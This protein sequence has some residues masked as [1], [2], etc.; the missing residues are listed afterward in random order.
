MVTRSFSQLFCSHV[1][2]RVAVGQGTG[3]CCPCLQRLSRGCVSWMATVGWPC[4]CVA[5]ETST[6]HGMQQ[7]VNSKCAMS[8]RADGCALNCKMGTTFGLFLQMKFIPVN[9]DS[10][11]DQKFVLRH[12]AATM[13]AVVGGNMSDPI[14]WYCTSRW[15][16]WVVRQTCIHNARV[17]C[18]GPARGCMSKLSASWLQ[19][20][21]HVIIQHPQEYVH[22]AQQQ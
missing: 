2:S 21:R 16:M 18:Q 5:D 7:I 10:E 8:V 11:H 13:L 22:M 12:L 3:V 15:W 17:T 6:A 14:E 19:R 1:E 4:H 20:T 9:N